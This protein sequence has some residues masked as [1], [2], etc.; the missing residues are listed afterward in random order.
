MATEYYNADSCASPTNDHDTSA[1]VFLLFAWF[2]V[3]ETLRSRTVCLKTAG[4]R[5]TPQDSIER[6]Q[7]T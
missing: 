1:Y 7:D 6:P 4:P 5:R 3:N 2:A